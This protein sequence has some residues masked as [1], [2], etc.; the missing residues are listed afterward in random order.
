M[1]KAEEVSRWVST[2]EHNPMA[3]A[4]PGLLWTGKGAAC[5]PRPDCKAA[6]DRSVAAHQPFGVAPQL[7][8]RC[9]WVTRT[10]C[11][12][13]SSLPEPQHIYVIR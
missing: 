8:G 6:A 10:I 9:L 1:S 12:A 3:V 13:S 5:P 2:C 11:R 7:Q 4:L